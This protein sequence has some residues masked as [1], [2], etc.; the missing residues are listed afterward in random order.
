M[1]VALT[2][3]NETSQDIRVIELGLVNYADT[4][5]AMQEFTSTRGPQTPDELWVL[6]HPPIY[7]LGLRVKQEN[8]TV[9]KNGVPVVNAD[10]G[11]KI[12]YHGPGQII[13]YTLI[14]LN[15]RALTVRDM[16]RHIENAVIDLLADYSIA[17]KGSRGAPGVYVA[18][19]KIAA[20]GLRIKR[21]CCYHGLALNVDMDLSPFSAIDPCGYPG[22]KVVQ[23]RDFGIPNDLKKLGKQLVNHLV[24]RLTRLS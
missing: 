1:S 21:G 13:V 7:T 12:T 24:N 16:V 22:L 15:R 18:G 11:G 20:L 23:M 9:Q 5:K 6:Q 14:D 19:A 2:T 3:R 4:V 17:A 10:R 8:P